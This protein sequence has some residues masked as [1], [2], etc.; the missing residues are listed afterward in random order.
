MLTIESAGIELV[1]NDAETTIVKG[2]GDFSIVGEGRGLVSRGAFGAGVDD[3]L[4][5][6][7]VAGG[8]LG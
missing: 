1:Y 5:A 3:R 6:S 7:L 4:T 8:V 2:E